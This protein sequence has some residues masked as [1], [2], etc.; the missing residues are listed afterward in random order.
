MKKTLFM[1]AL[2]LCFTACSDQQSHNS[3]VSSDTTAKSEEQQESLYTYSNLYDTVGAYDFT[4]NLQAEEQVNKYVAGNINVLKGVLPDSLKQKGFSIKA[5]KA[6]KL[7]NTN[8]SFSTTLTNSLGNSVQVDMG[9]RMKYSYHPQSS[10]GRYADIVNLR[11]STDRV[12]DLGE[13]IAVIRHN[14]PL[15]GD[16]LFYDAETLQLIDKTIDLSAIKDYAVADICKVTDGY[17]IAYGTNKENGF[18]FS[19]ENGK[20]TLNTFDAREENFLNVSY[21]D[22]GFGYTYTMDF[23]PDNNTRLRV[24]DENE[25]IA[26]MSFG[27]DSYGEYGIAYSFKENRSYMMYHR[28]SIENGN[29]QFDVFKRTNYNGTRGEI[30]NLIVQRKFKGQPQ[31]TMI[32]ADKTANILQGYENAS[33][34]YHSTNNMNQVTLFN[35]VY[36]ETAVFDFE[37]KNLKVTFSPTEKHLVRELAKT[38]DGRYSLWKGGYYGGGDISY[39]MIVLKDNQT[40]QLKYI[41]TIGG[42]YGGSESAGFFSN[43]DV[44]TIGLDEFKIFTTDMSQ[45]GP[46]FE[47]SE[48]FP[49]G[50][51]KEGNI[52]YR[53]LLAVRRNPDDHSFVVL[54]NEMEY[55]EKYEDSLISDNFFKSTYKIGILDPQGNLTKVYD[56]GEHVMTY[57]FRTVEMYMKPGNI[58]HFSVLIKGTSPQLEAELDLNTGKYT[59]ISGGYNEWAK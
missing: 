52:H 10:D 28:I 51:V 47:M 49:L 44:Y 25:D 17:I 34:P 21:N 48:H 43:G 7:D 53:D 33:M 18:A 46:V 57:A 38:P 20:I 36:G 39:G 27:E 14:N 16:V 1:L 41:D 4:M 9:A 11:L 24:L 59:H 32:L 19:D 37:N 45:Q 56:T 40:N 35:E 50:T 42:M 58:I 22:W 23:A 54:Y 5:D 12:A 2:L 8:I 30:E 26:F 13:E 3:D 6:T 15:Y 31:T 55:Y 29:H